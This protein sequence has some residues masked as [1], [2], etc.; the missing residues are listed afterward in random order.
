MPKKERKALTIKSFAKYEKAGFPVTNALEEFFKHYNPED[1]CGTVL[2]NL[3]VLL[4]LIMKLP[5]DLWKEARSTRREGLGRMEIEVA[6][7]W[8]NLEEGLF[9]VGWAEN[10]GRTFSREH[11]TRTITIKVTD[12]LFLMTIEYHNASRQGNPRMELS[13]A[14]RDIPLVLYP[15]WAEVNSQMQVQKLYD[16]VDKMLGRSTK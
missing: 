5:R 11:G 3:H 6:Y 12:G 2:E 16:T 7:P 4:G 9:T 8:Q 15:M 13:V 1:Y 14:T 10:I